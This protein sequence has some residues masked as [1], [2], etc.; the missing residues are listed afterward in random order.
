MA[1]LLNLGSTSFA[2]DPYQVKVLRP[3]LEQKGLW[4]PAWD[5]WA[6]DQGDSGEGGGAPIATPDFSSLAGYG[7]GFGDSGGGNRYEALVKDGA[8]VAG[9]PYFYDEPALFQG[10]DLLQAAALVGGGVYGMNALFGGLGGA[11]AGAEGLML[12]GEYGGAGA[13]GDASLLTGSSLGTVAQPAAG[14]TFGGS[15]LGGG[16]SATAAGLTSGGTPSYLTEGAL[17]PMDVP[18]SEW[19]NPT[20]PAPATPTATLDPSGTLPSAGAATGGGLLDYLKTNP[21]LVAGL[22]GGLLGGAD[23]G[24]GGGYSY[25]GPMPTITRGGWSPTATPT[26]SAPAPQPLLNTQPGQANSGLWRFMGA[27]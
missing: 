18:S 27:K 23:A 4:N 8:E 26:Y 3:L 10:Q 5:S 19:Q 20:T 13:L 9:N 7:A 12:A 15:A 2:D 6:N 17:T 11:T 1:G 14:L 21:R 24:G 16:L 22:A 25:S